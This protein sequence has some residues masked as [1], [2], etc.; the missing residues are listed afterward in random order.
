MVPAIKPALAVV[1]EAVAGET[2]KPGADEADVSN[3]NGAEVHE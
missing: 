2:A 3:T 1:I